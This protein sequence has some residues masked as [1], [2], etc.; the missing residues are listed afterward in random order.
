MA[1]NNTR[2]VPWPEIARRPE[3]MTH[4]DASQFADS[5][6]VCGLLPPEILNRASLIAFDRDRSRSARPPQP[7]LTLL[8]LYHEAGEGL[9]AVDQHVVRHARRY[10]RNIA[11]A[12][13]LLHAAFDR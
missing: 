5:D 10:M 13:R 12:Q 9:V 3:G 1:A 6:S 2:R 7:R 4:L 11:R 8:D